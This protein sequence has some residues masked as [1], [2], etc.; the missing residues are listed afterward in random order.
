MYSIAIAL[1]ALL[2]AGA[3]LAAAGILW[4]KLSAAHGRIHR[5]ERGELEAERQLT[6]LAR[7]ASR[8]EA[9]SRLPER[10]A[11]VVCHA[12]HGEE[13]FIWEQL[14]FK[15]R[16]TFIEIGAYDGVSLSNSL[17]FEQLGWKGVLIE[18]HPELAEKCRQSRPG[19][20]VVHA[21]LG[22]DDGGSVSFSMVR[23]ESGLDTLSF[24]STTEQHRNRIKA[25]SGDI[26]QV[27][28]PSRSLRGVVDEVRLGEVDWISVDVEGAE[29]E[30]LKGADLGS[31]RPR[32]LLV[33][34]NSGGS[35][36]GV[37]DFLSG[38]G[39]RLE[40]KIGCNDLYVRQS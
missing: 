38:F 8:A 32:V 19:A 12:Q 28:V 37:S 13:F 6:S 9:K 34:D 25:R 29:L 36:S 35:D 26:E 4:R 18:A 15:P 27:E 31:L 21:A 20:T 23:G 22:P 33:E 11:S 3:S 5:L 16:G 10:G 39:Y 1:L 2:V 7:A 17:F 40:L 30:V 24:V 14:G